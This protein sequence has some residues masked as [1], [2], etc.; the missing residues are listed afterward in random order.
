MANPFK[1]PPDHEDNSPRGRWNRLIRPTRTKRSVELT[2]H[3][4]MIVDW[5]KRPYFQR[6]LDY[7]DDESSRSVPMTDNVAMIAGTA[8]CNTFKEIRRK[9]TSDV[10]RA[11]QIIGESE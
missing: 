1:P 8:R 10:K 6:F 2:G 5:S 3:A 11:N 9:L 7:L 4:E